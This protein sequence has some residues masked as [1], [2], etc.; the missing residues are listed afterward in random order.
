MSDEIY[1]DFP[2]LVG[3][4]HQ[5]WLITL[6]MME[7]ARAL[8]VATAAIADDTPDMLD[9]LRVTNAY[10]DKL[11]LWHVA[12]ERFHHDIQMADLAHSQMNDAFS[13]LR[14]GMRIATE[15]HQRAI[16]GP[17]GIS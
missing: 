14:D 7:S 1:F 3:E 16:T 13:V 6:Q 9:A 11:R 10:C 17:C 15:I 12:I 5:S 8:L 2:A 4:L